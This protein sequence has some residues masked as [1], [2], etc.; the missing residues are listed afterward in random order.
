M[1]GDTFKRLASLS[2]SVGGILLWRRH[3]LEPRYL[4]YSAKVDPRLEVDVHV[5]HGQSMTRGT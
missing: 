1:T 5:S 4:V 3:R 2:A